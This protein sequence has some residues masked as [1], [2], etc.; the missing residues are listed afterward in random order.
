MRYWY[1]PLD[2]IFESTW[3]E[4]CWVELSWKPQ[5]TI[6]VPLAVAEINWLQLVRQFLWTWPT[7]L[8]LI[9]ISKCRVQQSLRLCNC[10][11]I[12]LLCGY[13]HLT[14]PQCDDFD[15]H[16]TLEHQKLCLLSIADCEYPVC[17]A[18]PKWTDSTSAT[19]NIS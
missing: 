13:W 12:A 17:K 11:C 4:L 9:P 5:Y 10:F 8:S 7:C 3:I 19:H 14:L 1:L 15:R 6:T 16:Q 2:T 18:D